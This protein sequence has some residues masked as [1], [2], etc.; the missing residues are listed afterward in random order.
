MTR[1]IAAAF[2]CLAL[3]ACSSAATAPLDIDEVRTALASSIGIIATGI[4]RED[5]LLAS[6]P[7]SDRFT[8]GNNVA[9]RYRDQG[10]ND[11]W[12]GVGRFREFFTSVFEIHANIEQTLDLRD[13]ELIG[14]VATA[15]VHNEFLSS[16]VDRLPPE[17]FT[18]AGWDYFV[19]E[20]EAGGWR[21]LSWDEAPEPEPHEMGEGEDI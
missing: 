12:V 2:V 19:F 5:P 1:A 3:G 10:W 13:V 15:R 8:M 9:V 17:N 11:Q 21:L 18:A 4:E 14:D 20:R 6:Q 7:V 16:R